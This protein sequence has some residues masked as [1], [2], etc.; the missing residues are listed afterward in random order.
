MLQMFSSH[1][2]RHDPHNHCVP[3]LDVIDLSGRR[4]HGRKLLVMPLLRQFD[5]PPFQTYGEFVASFTQICEVVQ[6]SISEW[7]RNSDAFFA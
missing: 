1:E 6:N 4:K 2:L 5:D 7:E 3:L